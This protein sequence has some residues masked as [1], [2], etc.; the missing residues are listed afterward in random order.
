MLGE[1]PP[2]NTKAVELDV[3]SKDT[4][5]SCCSQLVHRELIL[6]DH[7]LVTEK[8]KGHRDSRVVAEVGKLR[9][10]SSSFIMFSKCSL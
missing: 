5:H 1:A 6:A 9:G 3:R 4:E 2:T 10:F 8:A 7:L